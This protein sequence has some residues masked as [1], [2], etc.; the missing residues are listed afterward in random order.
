MSARAILV[1][2]VTK[3]PEGQT[4]T[5][6]SLSSGLSRED[7]LGTPTAER[8]L[9]GGDDSAKSMEELLRLYGAAF[10]LPWP[11]GGLNE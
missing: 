2:S 9:S 3:S 5:G 7:G 6:T 10:P 1:G 11:H 8:A 4:N